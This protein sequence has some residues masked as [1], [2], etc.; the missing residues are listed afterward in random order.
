MSQPEKWSAVR[1]IMLGV[2]ALLFLVGGVFTWS[3]A[4]TIAGAVIASGQ[5]EVESNR[6]IIQHPEGGVVGTI[7]ANDGD[8]VEAGEILIRL[9]DTM[10][11]SELA[12]IESQYYE[13]IA[14]R[15]RLRAESEDLPA[16]RFDEGLLEIAQQNEEIAELVGGQIRLFEARIASNAQQISQLRERQIQIEELIEGRNVQLAALNEQL[17]LISEELIDQQSLLDRGLAQASRV[18]SLRRED[19]SLRG[20]VGELVASVAESRGRI[21]ELEIEIIRLQ[22]TRQE[23]AITTLRD[24]QYR[25]NELRE[26]RLSAIET[27]SRLEIRAPVSGIVYGSTVHAVRSVI[28]PADPVMFIVPQDSPLVITSRIETINIDQVVVGQEAVLRFA[29]FDQRTTPELYGV[30]TRISADVLT[31]EVSGMNYYEAQ[32]LP[33]DGEIDKLQGLELVPGMPV[34]AFIQTGERSP[35]TF[36]TKPLTDYFTK[37]FRE[38]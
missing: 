21:A 35:L 29:A 32:I 36:L 26:R 9:D 31:D 17:G 37:A 33:Y 19:A 23:E 30:V 6:Q 1:P 18:L 34:D 25:E 5:L 20:Q 15:G 7:Y 13:L 12:I 8:M 10:L 4:T 3:I 24:M 22:T 14:R 16:I 11:R 38:T 27:L 28:R 2:L